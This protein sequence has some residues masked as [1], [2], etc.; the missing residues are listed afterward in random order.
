M[1]NQIKRDEISQNASSLNCNPCRTFLPGPSDE[2]RAG[3]FSF[4]RFALGGPISMMLSA[5]LSM[6]FVVLRLVCVILGQGGGECK[7]LCRRSDLTFR[8]KTN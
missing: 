7:L 2:E 8:P 6:S 3:E 1:E 4:G 5:I